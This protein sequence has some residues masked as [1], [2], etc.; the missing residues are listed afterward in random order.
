MGS[1]PDQSPSTS[2]LWTSS[3]LAAAEDNANQLIRAV[4]GFTRAVR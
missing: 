3:T 1:T 2:G 4:H